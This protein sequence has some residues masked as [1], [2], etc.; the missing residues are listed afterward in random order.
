MGD[1]ERG[2]SVCIINRLAAKRTCLDNAEYLIYMIRNDGVGSSNLSCGTNRLSHIVQE[3]FQRV[4]IRGS[5][6]FNPR[7][8]RFGYF[9]AKCGPGR[10]APDPKHLRDGN[11]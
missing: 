11:Q 9:E 5:A 7:F 3:G 2:R 8:G 4:G 10:L 1:N 6:G